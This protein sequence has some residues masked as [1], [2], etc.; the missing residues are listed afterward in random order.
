MPG[1][2]ISLLDDA[3][4]TVHLSGK[5]LV[6]ESDVLDRIK[7]KTN[8]AFGKPKLKEKELLLHLEKEIHKRIIGQEEAVSS[9]SEAIR[10]IR[11]GVETMSRPISF[12]FL[13]PTGVGKTETS[14]AL[15]SIYFGG[16]EKMIRLDMS[17]YSGNDALKRLLGAPPGEGDIT[18]GGELTEKI[19]DNPF[20][21][22]LL[23]EFEKASPSVLDLF[24]QVLDNGRLTDNRGKTVNF[25]DAII[26]ATSNAASEFIREQVGK[27]TAIDKTFQKELLEFLQTKGIFKPELLNRFD[28]I[29]VFKPL[30][31][32]EVRQITEL[33]LDKI[34]KAMFKQDITL[35]FDEKI[36]AKI[37]REGA[38]EEFGARPLRRY[39][40]DNIEDLLAQKILK[41]EIK[42]GDKITVSVNQSGSIGVSASAD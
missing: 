18:E 9:I 31:E 14:K 33:L 34:Y 27:G 32:K 36:I 16:E 6:E 28:G 5:L 39:I 29:I 23:D 37:V 30:G 7:A 19:Y 40:Q 1:A 35:N 4:N 22:V 41:D 8:V 10:R 25:S 26:I 2:S 21:L 15:S 3:A 12:L 17:E 20:S 38:D 13:G 24:L 42:R 11:S